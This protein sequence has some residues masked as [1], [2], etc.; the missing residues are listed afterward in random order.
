MAPRVKTTEE[1]ARENVDDVQVDDVFA[2]TA[3]DDS[4][5]PFIRSGDRMV[6]LQTSFEK[7]C[8]GDFVIYRLDDGSPVVRRIIAKGIDAHG[9]ACVAARHERDGHQNDLVQATQVI[10]R[11][12]YLE[13]NGKRIK[14]NRLNRGIFDLLTLYG[15]R[16]PFF[17]LT[18]CLLKMLPAAL[19][20]AHLQFWIPAN[21]TVIEGPPKG[22]HDGFPGER[23]RPA[24]PSRMPARPK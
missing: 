19:R 24:R 11:L 16:Q 5:S 12:A 3:K 6:F 8:V 14:A 1:F 2:V 22:N 7:M 20:P 9:R 10:G 4:V 15:T 18:D 17:R 13:S 23:P 21:V